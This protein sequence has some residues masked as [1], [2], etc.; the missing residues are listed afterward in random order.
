MTKTKTLSSNNSYEERIINKKD[1]TV[2]QQLRSK[3]FILYS[4]VLS[5]FFILLYLNLIYEVF[6]NDPG[7]NR[8][9]QS[10]KYFELQNYKLMKEEND[11]TIDRKLKEALL[12]KATI[13]YPSCSELQQWQ[14]DN[15]NKI[16]QMKLEYPRIFQFVDEDLT[17]IRTGTKSPDLKEVDVKKIGQD[18][19]ILLDQKKIY[20]LMMDICI[21]EYKE[22]ILLLYPI[23]N[24]NSIMTEI[25]TIDNSVD[26]LSH[27]NFTL[28]KSTW[29]DI[30]YKY[31]NKNKNETRFE[32]G[33]HVKSEESS[34]IVYTVGTYDHLRYVALS[35]SA[36]YL[37][38]NDMNVE[39]FVSDDSKNNRDKNLYNKC[40]T[41]FHENSKKVYNYLHPISSFNDTSEMKRS[42][43][44]ESGKSSANFTISC[45]KLYIDK[46]Y[47][48]RKQDG[49]ISKI[50]ALKQSSFG[51]ILYLDADCLPLQSPSFLFSTDIY[52]TYGAIFWP[53]F[54]GKECEYQDATHQFGKTA[55]NDFFYIQ[56]NYANISYRYDPNQW[57]YGQE[58][59]SGQFFFNK[60]KY[61]K[62]LDLV[63]YLT[64]DLSRDDEDKNSHQDVDQKNEQDSVH[65]LIKDVNHQNYLYGDKDAFRFAFLFMQASFYYV[66]FPPGHSGRPVNDMKDFERDSIIQY[67]PIF[68]TKSSQKFSVAQK[69]QNYNDK[70]LPKPL[71]MHQLRWMSKEGFNYIATPILPSLDNSNIHQFY[72]SYCPPIS[73]ELWIYGIDLSYKYNDNKDDKIAEKSERKNST[74]NRITKKLEQKSFQHPFSVANFTSNKSM[75]QFAAKIF[76]LAENFLLKH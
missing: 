37:L 39:I 38:E 52:K 31:Q 22:K 16:N 74:E 50:R 17:F 3:K 43:I 75:Q 5:F 8:Y 25:K 68:L 7:E 19:S 35:I 23:Q 57:I 44:Q 42:G 30:N 63:E 6:E 70:V 13:S 65:E 48:K 66:P 9:F 72:N 27:L 12:Q 40:Q 76:F 33:L 15:L 51:H 73:K 53:D 64:Y 41:F 47:P 20:D 71:F 2:F 24:L 67:D 54:W 11:Q 14:Q 45:K 1:Y 62:I 29:E 49:F 28:L 61:N 4:S 56:H 18:F 32:K 69:E 21:D 46:R 55:K 36:L 60:L 59:E 10:K 58:M 34:G 26:D